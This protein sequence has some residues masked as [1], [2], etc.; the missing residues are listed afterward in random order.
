MKLEISGIPNRYP[1]PIRTFLLGSLM[2]TYEISASL[3]G[4][5]RVEMMLHREMWDDETTNL[6]VSNTDS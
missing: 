5:M 6:N 2:S 1:I 3:E 4:M